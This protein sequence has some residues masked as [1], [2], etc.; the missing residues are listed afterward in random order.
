MLKTIQLNYQ[1]WGDKLYYFC[2]EG[3]QDLK[4]KF[5]WLRIP[6]PPPFHTY[7]RLTAFQDV[8]MPDGFN[9][10]DYL[11]VKSEAMYAI[12]DDILAIMEKLSSGIA[13]IALQKPPGRDL[14]YGGMFTSFDPTFYISI[15]KMDG[16][17]KAKIKFV[18]VKKPKQTED[19]IDIYRRYIECSISHG[20]DMQKLNEGTE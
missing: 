11:R 13:L 18:K 8:I 4:E 17:G 20:A 19:K 2:S 12:Q 1:T 10:I 14:A 7:R 9:I 6:V 3:Q 16:I 15:D 5:E